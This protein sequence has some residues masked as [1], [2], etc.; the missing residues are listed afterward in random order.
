M[1][2]FTTIRWNHGIVVPPSS[3]RKVSATAR[4]SMIRFYKLVDDGLKP[5]RADKSALGSLPTNGFRYCEPVRAAN[6]FGWYIFLPF[7]L[8]LQWTGFEFNWSIDSGEHWY[9]LADGVQYPYFAE[10]FD[11]IAPEGVRGYAPPFLKRTGEHDT[12]QIWTGCLVKTRAGLSSYIRSPVNLNSNRNYTILEGV[13]ETDWWFGPLFVNIK[14]HVS[15]EI[16]ILRANHPFIHIQPFCRTLQQEFHNSSDHDSV[17]LPSLCEQDWQNYHDTVVVRMKTRTSLGD[18]AR[19][20]RKRL[21]DAELSRRGQG[22]N[23]QPKPRRKR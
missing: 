5:Q 6:G 13:V 14:F 10:K 19:Q 23:E 4:S 7:D 1:K 15:N 8:H 12:L 18:Y 21:S 17:G 20:S 3:L 9:T 16:V 22:G 2:L 11:T